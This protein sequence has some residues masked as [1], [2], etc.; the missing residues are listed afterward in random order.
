MKTKGE[1]GVFWSQ[2]GVL[3]S[4]TVF[5]LIAWPSAHAVQPHVAA[6]GTNKGGT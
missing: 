5:L 1:K 2:S 4:T 6:G 3:L